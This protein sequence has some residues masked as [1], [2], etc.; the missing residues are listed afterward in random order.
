MSADTADMSQ[1]GLAEFDQYFRNLADLLRAKTK[2]QILQ[3]DKEAVLPAHSA[4]DVALYCGWYS[5]NN[6]IPECDFNPGAIGYHVAS[7]EMRSLH[8]PGESGWAAGLLNSGV[9]ATLG[10]VAEPYVGA[11]P[12][13]DDFFPLLLTGKLPLAEV[14]WDTVPMTSWMICMVGDPLYIP[15]KANPQIQV[16]DLPD[17]LKLI[18]DSAATQPAE[19]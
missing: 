9:A 12:R 19:P 11:F 7:Y 15:Y 6:Y 5:L 16:S 13:P 8:R 4:K 10:P 2:M 18:F 1:R 14:Y 3:D 17:R